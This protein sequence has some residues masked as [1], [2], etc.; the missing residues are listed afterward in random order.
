MTAQLHN[1]KMT[2]RLVRAGLVTAIAAAFALSVPLAVANE[3]AAE[4][5]GEVSL[6]LGRAWLETGKGRVQIN[7]GTSVRP[8]D[9]IV[10]ESNGH[11]H[12]R[13]VDDALVSVRPD[14][15][16][17]IVQYE[18]NRE[19]PQRSAIK[20][21]LQEGV[22]RSISGQGASAAR[23][24][25]RMNT[26]IAAIGVR[27]T[28]FVVS[29][30]SSSV[31]ALVNEGAIVLAPFSNEC[32]MDGFGPCLASGVELTDSALQVAQLDGSNTAP[33][34]LP[35]TIERDETMQEEI[36][37]AATD[38]QVEVDAE[39]KTAGTVNYLENVTSLRLK[40][41]VAAFIPQRPILKDYTPKE[42]MSA[43]SLAE[44]SL[45]WGRWGDGPGEKITTSASL[46]RPGRE[47][48]VGNSSYTLYRL[49]SALGAA[50]LAE[51][52]AVSF[53]L[54]SAQAF[55]HQAGGN[56]VAMAVNGGKLDIN[57]SNREF[58]TQLNMN[59]V[60]TGK[61]EFV[62]SGSIDR[63]GFFRSQVGDYLTGAVSMDGNEAAYFFEKQL[64]NGGIQGLTL[65]DKP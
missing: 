59:H 35:A 27:G 64:Q 26:P 62:S 54:D 57:F 61:V 65:W 1:G 24:R 42:S 40:N 17:E 37:V 48:T 5:V 3:P 36:Q 25:F 9:R 32:S 45:V 60:L 16:L 56:I 21:S 41:E 4:A 6:V 22:A 51:L 7:A 12:I 29:A 11:V 15:R 20:L 14:S 28:D 47:T 52:G 43:A 53:G 33:V 31:R 55:F 10:T 23:E 18:Y 44:N 2:G 63:Q 34:L 13:F 58:S 49:D 8:S 39:D 46:V 38:S 30:S 50:N 19:D